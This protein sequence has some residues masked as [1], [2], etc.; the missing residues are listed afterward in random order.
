MSVLSVCV[1]YEC[2]VCVFRVPDTRMDGWMN[3]P[4][5]ECPPSI[6]AC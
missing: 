5:D 1:G 2:A 4:E 3:R 6:T